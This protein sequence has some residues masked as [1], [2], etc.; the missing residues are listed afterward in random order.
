MHDVDLPAGA[1][2]EIEVMVTAEDTSVTKTYMASVYRRALNPSDDAKLSSLM[3]SG[4]PLMYMDDD[5]MEMT[6]FMSDVMA[7]TADAGMSRITVSA[8]A[9]HIAAQRGITITPADA[10]PNMDGHQVDMA[11]S[12]GGE[13]TVM[14]Q[15]LPESVAVGTGTGELQ[16]GTND[17][18]VAAASRLDDIECYMVTVT[19][20]AE[21]APRDEAALLA[22]YD[23]NGTDGVQIDELVRAVQDI[24][25]PGLL[26]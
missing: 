25:Q 21:Q 9:N 11:A 14:V 15:V 17:C 6:G 10:D 20:T 2:T 24:M 8:M 4:A 26:R 7:Y 23:T 16:A 1:V 18:S 5:D 22:M 13:V 12:V 19:R 3:L